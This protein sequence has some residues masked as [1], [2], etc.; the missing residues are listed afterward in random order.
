MPTDL[1]AAVEGGTHGIDAV[2]RQQHVA[3]L[4]VRRRKTEVSSQGLPLLDP[5]LHLEVLEVAAEQE[6]RAGRIA[7]LQVLA[8]E[9]RGI[10]I[11]AGPADALDNADVESPR[12]S[13]LPEQLD[14]ALALVA[15]PEVVADHHVPH[16]EPLAQ[17]LS[18]TTT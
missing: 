11:P 16:T 4:D 18:P 5:P 6:C 1:A 7:L 10:G 3:Q 13:Q 8:D 2:G 15:E 14:V 17:E 12:P 9:G